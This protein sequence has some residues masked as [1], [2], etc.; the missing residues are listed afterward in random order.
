[1]ELVHNRFCRNCNTS[2]PPSSV[3]SE[4]KNIQHPFRY[5]HLGPILAATAAPHSFETAPGRHYRVIF[6][7]LGLSIEPLEGSSSCT[8]V[9][10]HQLRP[11]SDNQ[12]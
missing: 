3:A 2:K 1:M 10:W 9:A 5:A 6:V 8:V 7:L 4:K 11:F 12:I